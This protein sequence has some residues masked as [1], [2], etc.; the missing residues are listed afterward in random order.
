MN[1]NTR[2]IP[3]LTGLRGFA[4]VWVLTRHYTNGTEGNGFWSDI[5]FHGGANGVMIFFGNSQAPVRAMDQGRQGRDQVDAVVIP[6]GMWTGRRPP[7]RS[8]GS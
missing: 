5:A 4:A 1:E 6:D 3:A 7:G 2:D 8:A